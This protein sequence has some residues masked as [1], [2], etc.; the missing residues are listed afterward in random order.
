M[1]KSKGQEKVVQSD[2]LKA[3]C[4]DT[5]TQVVLGAS[6]HLMN[7]QAPQLAQC[8]SA[9]TEVHKEVHSDG[10]RAHGKAPCQDITTQ[11]ELGSNPHLVKGQALQL[12]Q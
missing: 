5:A 12:A 8:I 1:Q 11:V 4:Q 10:L 9:Q 3:S 2:G 6:P 7:D